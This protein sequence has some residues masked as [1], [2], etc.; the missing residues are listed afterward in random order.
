[1]REESL[2][3][4]GPGFL[5][6]QVFTRTVCRRPQVT[7]NA[8]APENG[9]EPPGPASSTT[10]F[11]H[12]EPRL[13]GQKTVPPDMSRGALGPDLSKGNPAVA[14]RRPPEARKG[15][16]APPCK[17][18]ASNRGDPWIFGAGP[19]PRGHVLLMLT[20]V[21][22]PERCRPRDTCA[23]IQVA[24]DTQAADLAARSRG[25]PRRPAP[26]RAGRNLWRGV[27]G[28]GGR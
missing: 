2:A 16:E 9:E 17:P 1:M 27:A 4:A 24:A 3:A 21:L 23:L 26:R 11:L 8:P 5:Q 19:F 7:G 6:E 15:P 14:T 22:R 28:G 13:G 25:A 20:I 18:P 10:P 12:A